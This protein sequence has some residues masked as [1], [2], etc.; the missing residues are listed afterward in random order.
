MHHQLEIIMPPADD[1]K[2]AITTIMEPFNENPTEPDED[3][4]SNHSF[5]DFW[6]IGGRY[7]GKKLMATYAPEQITIFYDWLKKEGITVSRFRCGKQEL[8][9]PSQIHIVDAKWNEMF[10]SKDGVEIPCPIFKHSN[11]QYGMEGNSTLPEDICT[12]ENLPDCKSERVIIAA[13]ESLVY[14]EVYKGTLRAVYMVSRD[15]WNGVTHL[16]T[17]WDGKVKTAIKN[18]EEKLQRYTNDSRYRENAAPKSDWLVV[19]VD[20]HS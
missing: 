19:T 1:I 3:Y 14:G 20:V 7:S 4:C 10:P 18:W 12:V 17:T 5:W 11:D 2:A 9:P 15:I 8:D 6:V 13:P 16:D